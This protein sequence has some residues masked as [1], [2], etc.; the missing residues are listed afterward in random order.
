MVAE[1]SEMSWDVWFWIS[2]FVAIGIYIW[3]ALMYDLPVVP[4][5]D[6]WNPGDDSEF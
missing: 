5:W 4:L 2:I 1:V 6:P 3:L